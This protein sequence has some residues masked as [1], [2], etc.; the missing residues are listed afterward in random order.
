MF[1]L[2][3]PFVYIVT[4]VREGDRCLLEKGQPELCDALRPGLSERD[5]TGRSNRT[6]VNNSWLQLRFLVPSHPQPPLASSSNLKLHLSSLATDDRKSPTLSGSRTS[7][8]LKR[9]STRSSN[10]TGLP[11]LP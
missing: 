7:T 8:G 4:M 2:A 3:M 11:P 9:G 6:G 5:L 10:A 1:V